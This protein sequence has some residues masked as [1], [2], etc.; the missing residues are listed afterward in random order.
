MRVQPYRSQ[1]QP[2]QDAPAC[3]HGQGCESAEQGRCAHQPSCALPSAAPSSASACT[4]SPAA[5]PV[6]LALP[7]AQ[8]LVR[9]PAAAL[10]EPSIFQS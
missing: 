7:A 9:L 5:R 6:G 2:S 3:L 4:P 8:V 10:P 1:M